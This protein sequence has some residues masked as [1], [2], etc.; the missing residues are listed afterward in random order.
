MPE[1]DNRMD[2]LWRRT[3]PMAIGLLL[4]AALYVLT[5]KSSSPLH[6]PAISPFWAFLWTAPTIGMLVLRRAGWLK[7]SVFA[8]SIGLIAAL[9]F[10][11]TTGLFGIESDAASLLGDDAEVGAILTAALWAT[12]LL[13][14][15]IPA[16]FYQAARD[17]RR[18]FFPYDRLFLNAWTNALAVLVS[19]GFLIINWI[20]LALWAALFKTIKI[21]AFADLFTQPWFYLPFSGGMLGLGSALSREREPIIHALL[22]LVTTLFRFL[23]PTLACAVL[24]FL[25]A[26]PFTGLEAL[27]DT[28]IASRLILSAVFLFILFENAVIQTDEAQNGFW[29]PAE[30][31]VIATNIAMPLLVA[32]AAW[33]I[34]QRVDQHGWTPLRFYTAMAAGVAFLYAVAYCLSCLTA[35]RSWTSRITRLNPLLALGTLAAAILMHFPPLDPY[36]LSARDQLARL[37]D[38]RIAPERFDFAYLRFELGKTGRNAFQEIERDKALM[39]ERNTADSMD[40]AKSLQRYSQAWRRDPRLADSMAPTLLDVALYMEIMPQH[41]VPPKAALEKWIDSAKFVLKDC[42]AR[43]LTKQPRCWIVDADLNGDGI[44][45]F[46]LF[47]GRRWT[48]VLHQRDG[49]W[50]VG[51]DLQAA[52]AQDLAPMQDALKRGDIRVA[53]HE[54][55]MKD[56]IVGGVRFK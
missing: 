19:I 52:S 33:A 24:L 50:R 10:K 32:L 27:W 14:F 21:D 53:P 2:I 13:L 39:K 1:P 43:H 31:V 5:L 36:S 18:F 22:K 28:R 20:V 6:V 26:L 3:V 44:L 45:D 51:R 47:T 15:V 23:A 49:S 16:P 34:F 12:C 35:W 8:V 42:R 48:T 46:A 40:L 17:A 25:L 37:R 11:V 29:K 4:G 55:E 54:S 9:I 7:D 41:P 56:L 38:G 30:F